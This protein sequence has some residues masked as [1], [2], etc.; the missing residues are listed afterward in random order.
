LDAFMI[1]V[2]ALFST[3]EFFAISPTSMHWGKQSMSTKTQITFLLREKRLG[4]ST[5]LLK[6]L[7]FQDVLR[8]WTDGFEYPPSHYC[9]ISFY[10]KSTPM[11]DDRWR[12]SNDMKIYWFHSTCL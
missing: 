11:Q 3:L 5:S 7:E 4:W 2:Q 9:E 6:T 12:H 10:V 1:F 8:D